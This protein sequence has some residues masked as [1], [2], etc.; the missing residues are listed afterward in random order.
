MIFLDPKSD[1]AFKKLFGDITHKNILMSFLNSVLGNREG[2]K[3]IDVVLN[4]PANL[5]ETLEA[6]ASIVDV[7]CTDQNNN[8]YIVE[9]QVVTQKN[10]AARAQYYS[11]LALSRQLGKK[12]R[13]DLLVPVIFV[14]VLDFVLFENPH[15]ISHHFILDKETLA[16]ELQHFE[17]HFIEL[18][19]FT[20]ELEEL[21]VSL[22]SELILDKWI[23][24][25]KHA[26][27][28]Q[29]IPAP[30]KDQ[31]IQDAFIVLEQGNWS[32]AELEAYD[33]SLD[34]WR[35]YE[36]QMEA[37]KEISEA[38]GEARGIERG[39]AQGIEKGKLEAKLE[40]AKKLLDIA[41][42]ATIAATTDLTIEQVEELK[43][44]TK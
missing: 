32:R 14:G 20:K 10:Y 6:K 42:V 16:H 27:S 28:L 35:S 3:I 29:N 8:Q 9:M 37:A 15:Y 31:A 25:L 21:E 7:R 18:P 13:Y 41:D 39:M 1:V 22:N 34:A 2:K 11:A 23:Y 40:I 44:N 26:D 17:F 30:L 4:D 5:P 12:E 24:F 43:K 36:G 33:R 19:K 38:K